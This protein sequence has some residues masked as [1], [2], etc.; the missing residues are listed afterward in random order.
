M[1]SQSTQTYSVLKCKPIQGVPWS[2][3]DSA[4]S[5]NIRH[6]NTASPHYHIV[7]ETDDGQQYTVVIN[8]E[9]KDTSSP[10]LLY[11][12]DNNYQNSIT[13]AFVN[14]FGDSYSIEF[15]PNVPNGIALDYVRGQLFDHTKMSLETILPDGEDS[16]NTYIDGFVQAAISGKADIYAAGMEFDD[17][18]QDMGVHDIHMNQGNEPN[19]ESEDGIYQD[20]GLF[21]HYPDTDQWIAM[22]FAFQSQSFNTD[23]NGH[24]INS[25]L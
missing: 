8:I 4:P 25:N 20:G 18:P 10:M 24:R 3:E 17:D 16:L 22:F 13:S 2:Y 12:I 14:A 9:S 1:S 7:S 19:Y 15:P 21:I 5:R 11:Y 6:S 23:S